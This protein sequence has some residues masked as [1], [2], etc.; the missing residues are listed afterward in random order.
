MAQIEFPTDFLW[1]TA[2]SS[3]Q[4]EG[5]YQADGKGKSIWDEFVQKKGKI[6]NSDTGNIACDHYHKYQ[7][8]VA[9]LARLQIPAYRFSV[10]WPRI[11]P[12]GRGEVNQKGLDFYKALVDY[13]LEK[14][15]EPMLTLYHWDLPLALHN[16]GGWYNRQIADYF[17]EYAH[18]MVR[19]LGD[20]VHY[21]ITLNEPWIATV[22][23]YVLGIH[24]PGY[25]RPFTSLKVA[26]NMLLAHGRAMAAM[27]IENSKIKV[28][29]TNALSPVFSHRIDKDTRA[30]RRAHALMNTLWMDPIFK[31]E[32]P[33]ELAKKV[34]KQNKKNIQPDDLKIISQKMDFLGVNHYSRTIVR[35]IPFPL[36]SFR[37]VTPT[38]Q[39]AQFTS[40][41]WEIYPRGFYEL[42]HWI[43][44]E[45]NN[46]PVYITENGISL[47]EKA[48]KEKKVDDIKRIQYYKDYIYQMYL[49]IQEGC[50]VRGYFAWSFLDNLEWHLGYEKTFGLVYV[51]RAD[52]NLTRYPKESAYWYSELCQKNSYTTP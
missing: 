1:G 30:A 41:G 35:S 7:Q 18:L 48:N 2:T 33:Q 14:N 13:L 20:R 22:T 27:R 5:A 16:Q 10:A 17:A 34:Y 52:K 8:D 21:W 44:T 4:I 11:F 40:M 39:G 51:D 37:P 38:Y 24:A 6:K 46:P 43:R 32:Y 42:L 3:Y 23:G 12:Q 50:N 9:L 26:H 28:G 25:I 31:G 49:A 45:Y 36:Y 47:Y 15:I 29:I 19:T